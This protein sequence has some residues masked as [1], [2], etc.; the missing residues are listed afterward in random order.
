[1]LSNRNFIAPNLLVEVDDID[2]I[3]SGKE[4][5]IRLCVLLRVRLLLLFVWIRSSSP[6]IGRLIDMAK[7][8]QLRPW[9]KYCLH[10]E[11][12]ERNISIMYR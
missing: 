7:Y 9:A 6:T 2:A 8:L 3:Q 4:T 11:G 10:F 1:M 5:K 12:S